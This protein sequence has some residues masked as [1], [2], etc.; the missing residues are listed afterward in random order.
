MRSRVQVT[1][2]FFG[3]LPCS[4]EQITLS[5]SV[6]ISTPLLHDSEK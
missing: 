2:L 4:Y 1:E 6:A 3:G 5:N